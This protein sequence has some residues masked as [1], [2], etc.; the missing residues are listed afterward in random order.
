M[1]GALPKPA[2]Q[3]VSRYKPHEWVE[4]ADV[5]YDG[6]KPVLPADMP[7]QTHEWWDA[8]T[9]MPHCVLWAPTDW[10]YAVL[11]ATIHAAVVKG[12][13]PRAAELRIR[14]MHMGITLDA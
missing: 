12:D 1:R 10:Q 4:V 9:S 11:T 14:E 8:L 13:L 2:D 3:R 6:E 7:W 5:P